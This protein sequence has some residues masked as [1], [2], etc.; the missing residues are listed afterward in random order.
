MLVGVDSSGPDGTV[1]LVE[2]ADPTRPARHAAVMS[3]RVDVRPLP[4]ERGREREHVE[5]DLVG[6][7]WSE[8]DATV[9]GGGDD[10]RRGVGLSVRS[11]PGRS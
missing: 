8:Q 5:F 11:V 6:R 9:S 3:D 1:P 10:V 7:G 4:E 2:A